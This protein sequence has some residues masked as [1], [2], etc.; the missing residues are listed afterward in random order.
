V[1]KV[2]LIDDHLLLVDA[3]ALALGREG[4]HVTGVATTGHDGIELARSTEPDAAIIDLQL[5]DMSG[6]DAGV[7]IVADRPSVALIGLSGVVDPV[8]I[9]NAR[10]AGFSALLPKRT[11][12][13]AVVR[14][15]TQAIEGGT[16]PVPR[17]AAA[18]PSSHLTNREREVLTLLADGASSVRIAGALEISPNTVRSHIQSILMKLGA[19]SRLEAVALAV[20]D[21]VIRVPEFT[22]S[23]SPDPRQGI[24]TA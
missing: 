24:P 21:D 4:I 11:N 3:L 5:P 20:R 1:I 18:V 6:I 22:G 8:A 16:M 10:A 17:T 15:V 23:S 12:L 9:R 19:H 14:S 2:L 7:A 13:H